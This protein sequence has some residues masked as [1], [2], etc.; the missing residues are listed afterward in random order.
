MADP[1]LDLDRTKGGEG[2]RGAGEEVTVFRSLATLV[3]AATVVHLAMAQSATSVLFIGN[4]FTFGAGSPVRFYRSATVTDLNNE[5]IGGVPALFKAFTVQTGLSFDVSLETHSGAGFEYHLANKQGVL[6]SRSWD[7]VVMQGQSTM[8]LQKHGDP[9]KLIT[10]SRQLADFLRARNPKT[11]LYLMATWSR[12]DQTYPQTGAWFG[13]PIEAMARDVRAGNDKAAAGA[14]IK[15]V[16]PVG[17]AWTRAMKTGVADPNPYDGID[18]G[19]L[20]LWTSDHYHA[21]TPGYY[22]EALVV[23]GSLT[24]TDPRALGD[25]ECTAYE[26]GLDRQQVKALQQVAFDELAAAGAVKNPLASPKTAAPER[27]AAPR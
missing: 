9:T 10:T 3:G 8:D 19:K 21:S 12:A 16:I 22:L 5:G 18:A 14:S 7:K 11:E 6:G 2:G 17:E 25:G 20:D 13:K 4:S 24:G 26:L 1:R 27:C 15:T 23:F